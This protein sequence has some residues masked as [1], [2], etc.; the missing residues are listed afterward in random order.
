[1]AQQHVP[2]V[3]PVL[4]S[5]ASSDYAKYS[6]NASFVL[7]PISLMEL[8]KIIKN[9][10]NIILDRQEELSLL[11][12]LL[13]TLPPIFQYFTSPMPNIYRVGYH[14]VDLAGFESF[15]HD[16]LEDGTKLVKKVISSAH[17]PEI[18]KELVRACLEISGELWPLL[19]GPIMR[20]DGSRLFIDFHTIS[21]RLLYLLQLPR[22]GGSLPNVRAAHFELKTQDEIN[23][24]QWQ[25]SNEINKLRGRTLYHHGNAVTDIDA[26][27]ERNGVLLCVSCKSIVYTREHDVGDY[28]QVRNTATLV[29]S[30]VEDW[31]KKLN[32]IRANRKS[33]N[34]DFTRFTEIKGV[35]CTPH[36]FYLPLGDA[37]KEIEPGLFAASSIHELRQWLH[38]I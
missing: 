1:M 28:R 5:T 33:D 12:F 25:P 9:S 24:S 10:G 31:Q 36:A 6:V 11:L 13:H 38:N 7:F 23:H 21:Q 8:H 29:Q 22:G 19:P 18:A 3:S 15:I 20:L 30:A 14:V 32:F 4:V 17:I 26:I 37:T 27:G 2:E 16:F 35:V 34:Y